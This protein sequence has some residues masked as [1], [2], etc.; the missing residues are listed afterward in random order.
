MVEPI[1]GTDV[2][3]GIKAVE[4]MMVFQYLVNTLEADFLP[5]HIA[6]KESRDWVIFRESLLNMLLGSRKLVFTSFV[7]NCI[8]LLLN[9]Y[10]HEA[11]DA[12]EDSIPSERDS[13]KSASDL[14]SSLNLLSFESERAHVSL[15]KLFVMVMNLDLIR[16]EADTLGRTSRAD[17]FRNPIME[18]ILDEL[19][20]NTSYLSPFLLAFVEWKWKL[21]IILQYFSKYCG[22]VFKIYSSPQ[23][24]ASL[25]KSLMSQVALHQFKKCLLGPGV[26]YEPLFVLLVLVYANGGIS[27]VVLQLAQSDLSFR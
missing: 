8:Y 26:A 4:N 27:I 12:V 23:D 20:Y 11:T 18:V 3:S 22:K 2:H 10:H 9:Q 5:R 14:D 16:K 19:T 15:R 13:A 21:E 17:G 1:N 25:S 7:K 6:Y 24:F